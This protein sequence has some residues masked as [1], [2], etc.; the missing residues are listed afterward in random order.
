MN[1]E[2]LTL[3]RFQNRLENGSYAGLTGARRAVGKT[4][5]SEA[6]KKRAYKLAEEHFA[7]G[8]ASK[9]GR[10]TAVPPK[11]GRGRAA[12]VEVVEES[13]GADVT[14]PVHTPRATKSSAARQTQADIIETVD[15][16]RE[17]LEALTRAAGLSEDV[18]PLMVAAAQSFKSALDMLSLGGMTAEQSTAAHTASGMPGQLLQVETRT[19]KV[20]TQQVVPQQFLDAQEDRSQKI[21]RE[22]VTGTGR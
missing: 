4:D 12:V 16:M 17:G 14:A 8:G 3:E 9:G 2:K 19:Y 1:Y 13:K 7:S 22:T 5:W 11:R 18:K 20:P 6:Q 15:R 10:Q 21:F